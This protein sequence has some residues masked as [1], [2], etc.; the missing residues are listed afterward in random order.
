MADL[1]IQY[2]K[3]ITILAGNKKALLNLEKVYAD[4]MQNLVDEE[5]K[6]LGEGKKK[7]EKID[8]KALLEKQRAKDKFDSVTENKESKKYK[9]ELLNLKKHYDKDKELL[10][11]NGFD[12]TVLTEQFEQ[13]K[14]KIKEQALS[15]GLSSLSGNL[16]KVASKHKEFI[17]TYKTVAIASAT[18]DTY[19]AAESAYAS[20]AAFPPLAIAA[21]AAAIAAGLANVQQIASAKMAY[22]GIVSGGTPGEDSVPAMLMPGEVVWNPAHPNPALA[23]MITNTD[24]SSAT[25]HNYHISMPIT[26][27][28]SPTNTTVAQIGEV[29]EK[30]L[31]RALKRAQNMGKISAT[32]LTVRA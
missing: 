26:I 13:D 1:G 30:A 7:E 19:K 17:G 20:F 25:S 15:D 11:K 22:G 27:H 6:F 18:M 10:E 3:D 24:N 2:E 16:E 12:T 32:G 8:E 29:T 5:N 28:G 31:V 23:S 21:A 14:K 4:Q 9:N